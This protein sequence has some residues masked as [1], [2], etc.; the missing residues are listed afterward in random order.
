[1]MAGTFAR[2]ATRA[3][4]LSGPV[5]NRLLQP[6]GFGATNVLTNDLQQYLLRTAPVVG[7]SR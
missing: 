4:S 7:A 1:M 6:A 3:L 2:P 5:Q